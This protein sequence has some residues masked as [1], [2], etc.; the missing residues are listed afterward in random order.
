MKAVHLS[1]DEEQP[2]PHVVFSAKQCTHCDALIAGKVY[3]IT[4]NTLVC[5]K[6]FQEWEWERQ[7]DR[8]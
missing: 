7:Q 6:C 8:R 5:W 3:Q 1:V 4:S 2:K